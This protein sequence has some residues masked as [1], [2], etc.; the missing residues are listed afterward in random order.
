MP[1][2]TPRRAH[3][4]AEF[5]AVGC[6][7]LVINNATLYALYDFFRL[8]L[9][10]ASTVATCLAIGNN[11]VLNDRWTF[12]GSRDLPLLAAFVRFFLLSAVGAS[13]GTFSVWALVTF[14]NQQYLLANLVGIGLG[15]ASNF[16]ANS[17][18]TW[19]WR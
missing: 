7:G 17:K 5:V 13:I 1:S 6:S 4:F 18:W 12:N 8:P 9:I 16:A 14:L 3:Q 15:T 10:L 11:F 19:K 2:L